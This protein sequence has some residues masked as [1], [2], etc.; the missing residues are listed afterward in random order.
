MIGKFREL[1]KDQQINNKKRGNMAKVFYLSF[2]ILLLSG[3]Y[4][5]VRITHSPVVAKSNETVTFSAEVTSDG[6]GPATVQIL[7]NASLVQ[8]CSGLSAGDTCTYTGGPYPTYEGTTVAYAANIEDSDGK[9]KVRGYYYFSITDTSYNWGSYDYLWARYVG[10][11][12]D[13]EDFVFHRASDYTSFEAFVDDAGDK[14]NDVFAE[15]DRIEDADNF[16]TFNFYIYK[17]VAAGTANCGTV[18]A[19]ASTDMPWRDDD[20]ILHVATLA[21]CTQRDTI[22]HFTAEGSNTKAFLHESGH[23]V[24]NLADEYDGCYTYYFEPPNTP[25]IFDTEAGCQAEQTA[26]DRDPN[27]CFQFTSCQGGWWGIQDLSDNTVM[28]RGMVNDPWGI[29]SSEHVEWYFNQF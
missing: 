24:F 18:N 11:T 6:D 19:N 9:T 27:D 29:E 2:I 4:P 8:T 28:Q 14:I 16:D 21:D 22:G 26:Q 12:A 1:P 17:N 23:A 15:Q 3:C 20:A 25:N 10:A 7:V 5:D 13:K